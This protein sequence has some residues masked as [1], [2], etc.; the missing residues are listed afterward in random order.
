MARMGQRAFNAISILL[1][2]LIVVAAMGCSYCLRFHVFEGEGPTGSFGDHLLWAAV[3]SP[4]YVFL[5]GL[6]GAYDRRASDDTMRTMG[7]IIASSTLASMLFIDCAFVFRMVDLSRWL[8]VMFWMFAVVFSCLK[9]GVFNA[10]MRRRHRR[11]QSRIRVV[12]VGSGPAVQAYRAGLA[13]NDG[14]GFQ[15]VGSIGSAPV[16]PD[17]A[18][19]GGFDELGA[20][21][22]RTNPDEIVVSLGPEE[23]PLLDQILPQCEDS[24]IKVL[25]L[26]SYYPYLSQTPHIT[27]EGGIPLISVNHVALDNMGFAFAKRAFDL[28]GS[29]VLIVL[30]SPIMLIA[31][32]GTKISSPGPV[33]FKQRRVGRGREQFDM[34]KFRSMRVNDTQDSAWTTDGDPRRT[35]FGAFMRHYS[36]DE[37]PQLFNVLKGDMSL[38]GPRPELPQHVARFKC[39]VPL[40][41]VRH[42]VRPGM[43]GW[44]QINGLRGDTSIEER[45]SYDL[46]YIDNWSFLFDLRILLL[47]PFKGIVNKQESLIGSK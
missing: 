22:E 42:Q 13:S 9:A 25:I 29:A 11:G 2:L 6:L 27:M 46:Y 14:A 8:L 33:I 39:S 5:N 34:Y 15:L 3:F 19:L 10:L 47:T 24:G 30:T 26:P 32:I 7:R 44:A 17:V 38:V 45:V 40:Y 31:A 4:V 37:L 23:R 20:T 18:H 35:A 41:M 21:L 16:A 36:I 12:L 1:D 43:T 28:I